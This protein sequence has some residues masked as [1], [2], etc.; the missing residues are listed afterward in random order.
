MAG[1]Q[2]QAECGVEDELDHSLAGFH[3]VP[4]FSSLQ[5]LTS[6]NDLGV[7]LSLGFL[8]DTC[9]LHSPSHNMQQH[10]TAYYSI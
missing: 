2:G 5:R 4:V 10:I 1:R 6:I 3:F 7:A 9:G 8:R